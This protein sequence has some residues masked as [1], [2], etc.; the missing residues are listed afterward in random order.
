MRNAK[1]R[2]QGY[3]ENPSI[4][5]EKVEKLID[6]LQSIS[7]QTNRYG[8]PRKSKLELKNAAIKR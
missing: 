8:I 4:G 5:I 1:K 6:N 2:I 3:T 7:F